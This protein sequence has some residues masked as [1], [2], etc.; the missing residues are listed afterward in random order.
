MAII[1]HLSVCI[2]PDVGSLH[3]GD[4]MA[5]VN[6][7]NA[8]A[9]P[10]HVNPAQLISQGNK[11]SVRS[12]ILMAQMPCHAHRVQLMMITEPTLWHELFKGITYREVI[13]SLL[14]TFGLKRRLRI[15]AAEKTI[16]NIFK[17][18][19]INK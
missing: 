17:N 8:P 2:G 14:S 11:C 10:F 7:T 13:Q 16:K 1:L 15:Y 3:F 5:S 4:S 18:K 6:H 12:I 9:S 19:Y